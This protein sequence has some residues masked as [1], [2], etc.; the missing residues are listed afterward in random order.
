MSCLGTPKLRKQSARKT[1]QRLVPINQYAV[2]AFRWEALD[3]LLAMAVEPV[4]KGVAERAKTVKKRVFELRT[5][6]G[7]GAESSDLV[8]Q[9]NI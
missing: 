8:G 2:E 3:Y 4:S 1:S 6:T 7:T 5:R 9:K